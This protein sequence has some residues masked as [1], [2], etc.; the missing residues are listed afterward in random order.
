VRGV[1]GRAIAGAAV[2]CFFVTLFVINLTTGSTPW[3]KVGVDATATAFEDTRS[4]TSSWDCAHKGIDAFPQ[5]PCDPA[6][7]PTN[8]PRVWTKLGVFGLGGGATETLGVLTAVLFYLA[9]LAVAGPLSA[10]EGVIYA[11]GLL[12][13]ATLLGV[14]RG[15][16]DLLMFALVALG[17]ILLGRSA[18]TGAAAIVAAAILKLYPTFALASLARLRSR[19]LALTASIV[20]LVVYAA[21]TYDDIRAI[22]HVLPHPEV[23]AYGSFVL[24]YAIQAVGLVHSEGALRSVRIAIVVVGAIPAALVLVT[25]RRR[26][27]AT[28]ARRIDAFAAG[29][30]LYVGSYT[31]G[32]NFDYRLVFLLLCVPQLCAWVRNGT[33]P[34]PWPA[35]ALA[36][37]LVTM[38]LSSVYPPLPFGLQ[39]WYTGLSLPPEEV[40]NW[41]LFAWLLAALA[42]GVRP[43][44]QQLRE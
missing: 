38:F 19:W 42:S 11:L 26:G 20:V 4:I 27:T 18:W 33:S 12:A 10:G 41:L 14:E 28:D 1:D 30:A 35:A 29:A 37:L 39:S 15:N 32:S 5:N 43:A 24:A 23:E 3:H 25:G 17:I 16:A 31:F 36:S 22:L 21:V 6:G 40:L 7:R 44:L 9:A 13:P 34:T 8:Y 2:A